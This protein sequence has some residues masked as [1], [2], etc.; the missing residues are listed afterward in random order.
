MDGDFVYRKPVEAV[1]NWSDVECGQQ[2]LRTGIRIIFEDLRMISRLCTTNV[3]D[4]D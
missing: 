4:A 2:Y 3:A 1:E